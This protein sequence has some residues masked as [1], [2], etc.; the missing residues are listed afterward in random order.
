MR[1]MVWACIMKGRK[2]PLIVLAY[3]GGK[4]GRMNSAQYKDQVLEGVLASF[5][6]EVTGEMA[7]SIFN[8][9]EQQVT[10]VN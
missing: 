4:G 3:P 10:A 8:R 9:M 7:R 2:G 6:A 1:V 5:H